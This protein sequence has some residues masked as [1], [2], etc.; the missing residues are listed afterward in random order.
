MRKILATAAFALAVPGLVLTAAPEAKAASLLNP[1]KRVIVDV[2]A[3]LGDVHQVRNRSNP[4][5]EQ[6]RTYL[7][8]G[9]NGDSHALR[10]IGF[11]YAKGWGVIRD[12]TKAYMWFTLAGQL[13][14]ADA[15]ENRDS[16]IRGI[17]AEK[18]ARA[19]EMAADWLAS[20]DWEIEAGSFGGG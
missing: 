3:D 1:S 20:R 14:N 18:I 11:H 7:R 17:S 15:L 2:I 8:H 5:K 10:Q 16:M 19:E 9:Q 6:L 13:G 12:L 4:Y